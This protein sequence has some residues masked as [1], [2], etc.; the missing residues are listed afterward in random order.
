[1]KR[2]EIACLGD[3]TQL[4]RIALGLHDENVALHAL[5]EGCREQVALFAQDGDRAAAEELAEIVGW[6]RR[7]REDDSA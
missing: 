4:R 3:A 1:M 7:Q 2:E 5:V 6:P